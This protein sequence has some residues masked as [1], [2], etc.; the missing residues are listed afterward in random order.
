MAMGI[1]RTVAI[2]GL[3]LMGSGM[4]G[5]LLSGGFPV[6]VYNRTASRAEPLARLGA[7]VA[8]TPRQAAEGAGVVISMVAD[9]LAARGVWLGNDGALAGVMRGAVLVECSTVSVDWIGDLGTAAAEH[10]CQ[11]LD[12]PVTG[13]KSQAASGELLFL[14]GGSSHA[15]AHARPVLAAMSRDFVHLGPCGS[16]ALMKLINN[17]VCGVQAVALAEALA[18]IEKSGLDRDKAIGVIANGAPGSPLVKSLAARMVA[19][20][21]A[22]HF[23]LR[24]MAKD[25]R[26]ALKQL[27]ATSGMN[28]AAAA[29]QTFERAIAEGLG[30]SDLSAVVEVLR[31]TRKDGT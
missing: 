2:L 26:Y 19:G 12:A 6:N 24:L 18:A 10:G 13:S 21:F 20:D 1:H 27:G 11:L 7:K 14:I 29:L 17:F 25:L 4:A 31:T 22:P 3:G 8:A 28:T 23:R 15:L 30:E 16:G 5:R 9:D